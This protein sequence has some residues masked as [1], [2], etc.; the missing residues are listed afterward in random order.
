[1]T[2]NF[3]IQGPTVDDEI[4]YWSNDD[5]WVDFASAHTYAPHVVLVSWPM[6]ATALVTLNPDGTIQSVGELVSQ[7]MSLP[8]VTPEPF[9]SK[10][11][12]P[13]EQRIKEFLHDY[14]AICQEHQMIIE[15]GWDEGQNASMSVE[16]QTSEEEL[17]ASL[18]ELQE[19]Y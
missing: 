11:P 15:L 8:K 16:E 3:K 7:I 2:E 14:K 9:V 6:E 12:K 19:N 5:G 10:V 17:E 18:K 13:M 4:L 1:M